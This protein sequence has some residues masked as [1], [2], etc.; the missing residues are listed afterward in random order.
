MG[1]VRGGRSRL[2]PTAGAGHHRA[3]RGW[4]GISLAL[5]LL[6]ACNPD[7]PGVG[8]G[9][10]DGGASAYNI[11]VNR[12]GGQGWVGS[13]PDGIACG[14]TCEADFPAGA[15]VSLVA[16][17]VGTAMFI[18]W[19]GECAGTTPTCQIQMVGPRSVTAQFSGGADAGVQA[20]AGARDS[21]VAFDAGVP[22]VGLADAG[23][24]DG[25]CS[26]G[27]DGGSEDGGC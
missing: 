4:W 10:D 18:G 11:R 15:T 5:G 8:L 7:A 2:T 12:I 17:S 26:D 6:A 3:V 27:G 14:S 20:D 22:D 1:S 24:A 9:D 21:G 13:E 23:A 19:S 16:E 25:G